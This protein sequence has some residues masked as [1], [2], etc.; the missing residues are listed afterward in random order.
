VWQLTQELTTSVWGGTSRVQPA[1]NIGI[2]NSNPLTRSA[3]RLIFTL[4]SI[5][6]SPIFCCKLVPELYVLARVYIR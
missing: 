5:S 4:A 2:N 3:K 6:S 1:A